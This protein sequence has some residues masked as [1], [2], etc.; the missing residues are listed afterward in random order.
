M[1]KLEQL[2]SEIKSLSPDDFAKLRD[3]LLELNAQQWDREFEQDATS[4]KLDKVFERSLAD[5]RAGK[6]REI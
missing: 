4:G 5:H 2:E 3:W 1:T 6:S